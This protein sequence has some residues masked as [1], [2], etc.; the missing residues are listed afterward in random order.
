MTI[1]IIIT[2][3]LCIG[4]LVV[5]ASSIKSKPELK[6]DDWPTGEK[7]KMYIEEEMRRQARHRSQDLEHRIKLEEIRRAQGA[8]DM[9]GTTTFGRFYGAAVGGV[10]GSCGYQ[11]FPGVWSYA[12]KAKMESC[13]MAQLQ[14]CF[15][16][17]VG[18]PERYR[19]DYI[20]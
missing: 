5:A 12:F 18:F 9:K 13:N 15:F 19:E 6:S 3:L 16:D 7:F 20:D 1:I 2:V 17:I 14:R 4:G 8:A 10:Q 11:S